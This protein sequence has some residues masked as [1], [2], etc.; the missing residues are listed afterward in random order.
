MQ[1][2]RISFGSK[3][4][5]I[6]PVNL[7]TMVPARKAPYV[8]KVQI[9]EICASQDVAQ[10]AKILRERETNKFLRNSERED[11]KIYEAIDKTEWLKDIKNHLLKFLNKE[12]R[13]STILLAKNSKNKIIGYI[14]L[15]SEKLNS[16]TGIIQ[17]CYLKYDYDSS[18]VGQV[19]LYKVTEASKGFFDEVKVSDKKYLGLNVFEGVGYDYVDKTTKQPIDPDNSYNVGMFYKPLI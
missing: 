6:K 7:Y 3:N 18:G 4:S 10:L 14:M 19:M 16:K 12:D 13:N 5:P 1:I 8:E 2:Q 9:E 17:D 11:V 15:E